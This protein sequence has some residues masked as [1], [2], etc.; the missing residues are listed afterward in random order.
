M[1]KYRAALATSDGKNIDLHF[2]KCARFTVVEIN[3]ADGEWRVVEERA[4][5]PLC[6][7]GDSDETMDA[8]VKAISD[9]KFV[10]VSRIGRWPFAALYAKG[11]ECVEFSGA[12][13]DAIEKTIKIQGSAPNPAQGPGALENPV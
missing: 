11:I 4:T 9:C 3:G 2:G 13:K 10:V 8:A 6:E 7:A 1:G 5:F 12:I